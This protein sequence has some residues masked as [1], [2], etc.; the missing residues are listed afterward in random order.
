MHVRTAS[1]LS[2]LQTVFLQCKR[3]ILLHTHTAASLYTLRK[4]ALTTKNMLTFV[5]FVAIKTFSH[6]AQNT[7]STHLFQQQRRQPANQ[8]A[9]QSMYVQLVTT[10]KQ[11][12]LLQNQATTHQLL[13]TH[14]QRASLLQLL[15]HVNT[16]RTL[17]Q[18]KPSAL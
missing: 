9:T 17:F 11:H 5:Q 8:L 16:V 1:H 6:R 13:H 7:V 14:S 2:L 4:T 12:I 18:V 15:T 10:R 3:K